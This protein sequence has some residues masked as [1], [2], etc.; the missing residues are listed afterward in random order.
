MDNTGL[1]GR[2]GANPRDEL[3]IPARS[4]V[5]ALLL[6]MSAAFF[7]GAGVLSPGEGALGFDLLPPALGLLLLWIARRLWRGD[8]WGVAFALAFG[9]LWTIAGASLV[10]L[11]AVGRT[12]PLGLALLPLGMGGVTFALG[13]ASI[14]PCSR[15]AAAR[16]RLEHEGS[17][18]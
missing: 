3:I 11:A 1:S 2:R 5:M 10:L 17:G 18:R 16:N 12:L 8:V 9:A 4:R 7:F 15:L 6:A 13:L 14:G